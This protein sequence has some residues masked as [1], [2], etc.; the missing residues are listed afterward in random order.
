MSETNV[1]S[2]ATRGSVVERI[3][4]RP[5]SGWKHLKGAV[6]QH[7]TGTRIHVGGIARLPDNTIVSVDT[8]PER[9]EVNRMIRINGG[10]RK[11]GMMA[12]ALNLAG[13]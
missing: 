4:M 3:V 6:W 5:G 13:A 11:R 12:W 7:I 2:P 1:V 8:P 10:N 9:I